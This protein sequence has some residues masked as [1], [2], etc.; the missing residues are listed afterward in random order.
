MMRATV[1]IALLPPLKAPMLRMRETRL[2]NPLLLILLL[3]LSLRS[4]R[5]KRVT[6]KA[7]PQR[8]RNSKQSST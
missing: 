8:R 5:R 4:S 6:V 2:R 7:L 1:P 3:L